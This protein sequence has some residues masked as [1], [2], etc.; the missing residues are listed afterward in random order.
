MTARRRLIE[1]VDG[2]ELEDGRRDLV[3]LRRQRLRGDVAA[4]PAAS[5]RG[6]DGAASSGAA[7]IVYTR[8]VFDDGIRASAR[9][10]R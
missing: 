2:V 7:A 6:G 4:E 8:Q 5:P 9:C 10:T 3:H 1:R